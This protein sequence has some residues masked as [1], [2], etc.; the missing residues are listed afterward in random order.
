MMIKDFLSSKWNLYGVYALTYLLIGFL[1]ET[2]Q[3]TFSQMFLAF[4]LMFAGN[5]VTYIY[6]MGR[7]MMFSAMSRP[8][9]IKELDKLN[10]LMKNDMNESKLDSNC[11]K[12][13]RNDGTCGCGKVKDCTLDKCVH[14][15]CNTDETSK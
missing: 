15:T 11:G 8:N 13:N 14:P 12:C 2:T 10:E 4:F 1:F 6:G 9:F 7:G 3:M 5:L